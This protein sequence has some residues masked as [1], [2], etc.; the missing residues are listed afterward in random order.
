MLLAELVATSAAVAATRARN[1]KI[2]AIAA[3]LRTAGPDE[4]RCSS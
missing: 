3:C 4:V 2:D 1:A